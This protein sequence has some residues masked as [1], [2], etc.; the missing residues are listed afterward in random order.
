MPATFSRTLL[1]GLLSLLLSL[2]AFAA[3]A[4]GEDGGGAPAK[5]EPAAEAATAADGEKAEEKKEEKAKSIAEITEKSERLDGLFTLFRDPKAGTTRMLLRPE[6]LDQ[7]YIYW[8]Q[9]ANGIVDVGLFKGAYGS[10]EILEFRRQFDSIEIHRK[11]TSFYFDPASPLARAADANISEAIVA[12]VKIAAEDEETGEI[13]IDADKLFAT[14]ALMQV[15]PTPQPGQDPKTT[16]SLGKLDAGRSRILNLRSYPKNTDVEVRYAFHNPTPLVAGTQAV[17]DARNVAIRVMH[18]FIAMPDSDYKP[19]ADDARV[20]YFGGQVTDLTSMDAAPYRDLIARWNLVKEK[21]GAPMS[22][23]VT[24]ITWW[25]ENTTPTEYRDLIRDAAL[26]WN[27]SFEKIG[28]RNA[29]VVK[30]QPDDADWDAGDIRYNVLRWTSSPN[31]PF[32]GYGPSFTNPRTGEIIGADVMLEYSFMSRRLRTRQLIQEPTALAPAE[33]SPVGNRGHFFAN[34]FCSLQHGLEVNNVFASLAAQTLYGMDDE[35]DQQLTR[36]TMHYLILHELGH[37]LG[38]NHNMKATQLLTP[39][40]ARDKDMMAMGVVAGSVMDYPAVNFAPTREEQTLF[41]SIAP[42]P[43]DDWIIEYGYSEALADPVAERARLE[44]I[45][46]KSTD[47]TLAFGN[48]ADDMRAPGFGI[49]PRVNIYDM[50]S[51]ALTFAADQIDIMQSTLKALPS[52]PPANGKSYQET[53][54][55][56]TAL[57]AVWR[58]SAMVASRYV[59]GVQVDRAVVGQDGGGDPL[60]PIAADRQRE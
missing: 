27:T 42:G 41:Y 18:S 53:A 23:P 37:T 20:G 49:D 3:D 24:P 50:T 52:K 10:S 48:D 45:L 46:A 21:P 55:G 40:Q 36:D 59:G 54:A 39:A 5:A 33:T 29:L 9:V 13:L 44:K 43:Y 38:F 6:Q 17:T 32:G 12:V 11:N 57:L 31:P 15:T 14:E 30:I 22:E 60:T 1:A 19:R 58:N 2:N 56:V 26:A 25:I 35:I 47:P 8:V 28:F 16:F 4:D 51:D 34:H 7:E